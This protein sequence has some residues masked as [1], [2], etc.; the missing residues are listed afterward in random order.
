MTLAKCP[1]KLSRRRQPSITQSSCSSDKLNACLPLPNDQLPQNTVTV[2]KVLTVRAPTREVLKSSLHR[3]KSI[4][5]TRSP[6]VSLT[7]TFRMTYEHLTGS[8]QFFEVTHYLEHFEIFPPVLQLRNPSAKQE[9]I[10]Y[11]EMKT[12]P[13]RKIFPVTSAKYITRL[14]LQSS[15]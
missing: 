13:G 10:C 7:P 12:F 9:N 5:L 3:G 15:S 14:I 2:A 1:R 4:F 6:T 8:P 11:Q